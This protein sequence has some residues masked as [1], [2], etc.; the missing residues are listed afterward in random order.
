MSKCRSNGN[1]EHWATNDLE[2]SQLERLALP[3]KSWGIEQYHRSIKQLYG[4]E[5]CQARTAKAQ[6]N[7]ITLALHAFLRLETYSYATGYSWF[8]AKMQIVRDAIRAYL[9]KPLYLLQP[10]A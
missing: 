10:T 3:E 7:R 8:E 4:V 6:R 2:K 9:A 1:E 5:K